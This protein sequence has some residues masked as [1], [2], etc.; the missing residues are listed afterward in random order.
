MT[1]TTNCPNNTCVTFD[2]T[3]PIGPANHVDSGLLSSVYPQGNDETAMAALK[4]SIYRGEPYYNVDGYDYTDWDAAIA[5]GAQTTVVLSD[6]WSLYNRADKPPTP[7]SN[8]SIYN[9][10]VTSTV[11]TLV[12]SGTQINYWEVYNEPGGNDNYYTTAGYNSE[13]PAVLLQEFLY[14]Y[15]DI[16]A[17]DP[18]AAVVGPSLAQWSDYPSEFSSSQHGFDMVTF[19][20]YAVANNI[21]LAA[22]TWHEIL[23]NR[24][25]VLGSNTLAPAILDD[26]VA[27]AR[28]LLAQ[29]PS[30]GN[31]KIFINEYGMPEVHSIPG[32]DVAYL[33]A[34]TSANVDGAGR[35]CW[36]GDCFLPDLDGLL[37]TNGLGTMPDY[38]DRVM[39]AAM[40]GN[41]ITT[42]S[43]SDTVTALGSYDATSQT[44]TGLVGQ[45]C[46][47]LARHDQL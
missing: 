15:Q 19:L 17:V 29:R 32:W 21:Q 45:R 30:L 13:T 22:L 3:T 41:M 4:T 37:T 39:Y 12:A 34:L 36:D 40:S 26:H 43:N 42:G 11:S 1:L 44:F 18:S 47:V 8:W 7:W 33:A 10:W 24:G 9:S 2:T 31:P 20:N 23:N 38:W 35:T 6:L 14:T 25:P 5:G 16:K 46:R 28:A 27:E